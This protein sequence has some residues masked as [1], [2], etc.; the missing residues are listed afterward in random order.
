MTISAIM[1]A[2][3]EAQRI[4]KVIKSI[5]PYANEILVIDDGSKDNTS[6][7]AR[8]A[9]ASVIRQEH[10]GYN[11]ALKRGFLESKHDII[12]TI[13]ADG[14]HCAS[15]IPRLASPVA[16]GDADVVL[17]TRQKP[18]RQSESIINWMTN[19]KVTTSDA[20][21]GFRAIRKDLA[22]K[23]KLK[24]SCTCGTLVLEANYLGARIVDIPITIIEINRTRPIAWYHMKQIACFICWLLRWKS[25]RRL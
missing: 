16:S 2:Y 6:K 19:L 4:G 23:L 5:T 15:D 18:P 1:P 7:A 24:G 9:G 13:D 20:C 12:V 17:G 8:E 25:K 11:A 3:N 14:E 10:S 22:V 21:T